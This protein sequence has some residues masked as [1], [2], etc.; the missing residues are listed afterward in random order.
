MLAF[1]TI[2]LSVWMLCV[3]ILSGFLQHIILR[4]AASFHSIFSGSPLSGEF[5][6]APPSRLI[7]HGW[8]S[9]AFLGTPAPG[10]IGFA[11]LASMIPFNADTGLGRDHSS[12][13]SQK[14][15][16]VTPW[17]LQGTCYLGNRSHKYHSRYFKF[18]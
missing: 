12:P 2:T 17:A 5:K 18:I 7:R 9:A 16:G 14:D 3:A 1:A 6:E 4:G 8:S 10:S 11:E 13:H 15:R